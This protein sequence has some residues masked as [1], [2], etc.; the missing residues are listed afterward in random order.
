MRAEHIGV[1]RVIQVS[2]STSL[3]EA[4]QTMR[5]QQVG[6]LVVVAVE[7][8]GAIPIGV[9]TDRDLTIRI[10]GPKVDLDTSTVGDVMSA[11]VIL[12][13]ADATVAGIVSIMSGTRVRRL[14]LVDADGVLAGIVTA[15]DVLASIT[16]MM[17]ELTLAMSM[18]PATV[19]ERG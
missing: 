3:R 11:P 5:K 13:P 16:E 6:C 14:P 9:V 4:A 7:A 18:E 8:R 1:S 10:L 2:S 17:T 15:D 19:T 12:C